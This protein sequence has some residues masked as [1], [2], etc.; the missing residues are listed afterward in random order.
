MNLDVYFVDSFTQK[1]F[2]GNAAG[3]IFHSG[4][5]T[6]SAMQNI[7]FENNLSETA[8]VD[9]TKDN[10]IKFYSPS[11]EVDLCGHATL[12]SAFVYFNFINKEADQIIFKS[13][14]GQL[15]TTKK[16]D[17]IV[18]SLPKDNP[19]QEVDLDK[20]IDAIGCNVKEAYK[21]VDDYLLII[22]N[23][24]TLQDLSPNISKIAAI[25]SRG[26]IVSAKSNEFDFVSRVFGPN[27]GVDEDPVTGSAHALLAPYW[28][29][30]LGKKDLTAK[31]LSKRQGELS[32]SVKDNAVE[33]TGHAVL[34]LR[35]TIEI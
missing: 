12:A 35:G 8:F 4:E 25:P 30:I 33:I 31:Q 9:L 13:N 34:Y 15:V 24:E 21:G 2:S 20:F 23:E 10:E 27:V 5:L 26:V 29:S 28:A 11:V 6:T 22:E 16:R 3:V 7:A 14:R 18:M 32:C 17:A 19:E 1:V